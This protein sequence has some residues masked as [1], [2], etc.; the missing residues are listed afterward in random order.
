MRL[1]KN[2]AK[3]RNINCQRE[4]SKAR[5]SCNSRCAPLAIS[6]RS[7]VS[8]HW[9]TRKVAASAIHAGSASARYRRPSMTKY[10]LDANLE[11]IVRLM[12]RGL[13]DGSTK[14]KWLVA[15]G[16]DDI[17]GAWG[18]SPELEKEIR[19]GR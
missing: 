4:K 7:V 12:A 15:V 6:A 14:T 11:N 5:N 13:Q 8:Q 2:L 16:D 18:A 10:Y 17:V 3:S 9:S 19:G 1:P